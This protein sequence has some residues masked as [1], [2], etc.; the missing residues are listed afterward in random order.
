[1]PGYDNKI[2]QFVETTY[3]TRILS[4]PVI[5]DALHTRSL[6]LRRWVHFLDDFLF[7]AGPAKTVS[8][9]RCDPSKT[10]DIPLAPIGTR[11][12]KFNKHSRIPEFDYL[13]ES[14]DVSLRKHSYTLV[15]HDKQFSDS[16]TCSIALKAPVTA[17][18][19]VPNRSSICMSSGTVK[20]PSDKL[21]V[22]F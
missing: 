6:R 13:T 1:M 2:S 19:I 17:N 10:D 21:R 15:Q 12:D 3:D 20:P 11:A 16:K 22:T 7:L 4:P 18:A 8:V 14:D 5:A 9:D